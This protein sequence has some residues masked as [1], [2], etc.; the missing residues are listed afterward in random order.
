[1]TQLQKHAG[2]WLM[3]SNNCTKLVLLIMIQRDSR[4][5]KMERWQISGQS[6]S[7][8]MAIRQQTVTL[9]ANGTVN[10]APLILPVDLI[11]SVVPLACQ[12]L[13]FIF[14]ARIIEVGGVGLGRS[15]IVIVRGVVGCIISP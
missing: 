9:E 14:G 10:G 6:T 15:P 12:I 1:M 11:F 2:F 4:N 8:D 13:K 3:Q 5:I 7:T